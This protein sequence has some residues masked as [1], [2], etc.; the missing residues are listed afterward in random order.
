MALDWRRVR[1]I[2]LSIL[3]LLVALSWGAVRAQAHEPTTPRNMRQLV[4]GECNSR[5][6]EVDWNWEAAEMNQERRVTRFA[7]RIDDRQT[8]SDADAE[9][10]VRTLNRWMRPVEGNRQ[11]APFLQYT[12]LLCGRDNYVSVSFHFTEQFW[13]DKRVDI[14]V[15]SLPDGAHVSLP[16]TTHRSGRGAVSAETVEIPAARP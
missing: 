7:L 9:R 4:S 1:M 12:H 5:K 16:M 11:T 8:L 3:S 15:L 2:R 10:I 13:S 14:V 6:Y